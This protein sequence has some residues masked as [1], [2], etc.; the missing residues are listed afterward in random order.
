MKIESKFKFSTYSA[1]VFAFIVLL[2]FSMLI[3]P[4]KYIDN[5]N[6]SNFRAL[7]QASASP[8]PGQLKVLI[9]N[10]IQTLK[11][12]DINGTI[13][14]L[15]AAEQELGAIPKNNENYPSVQVVLTFL[16][17]DVIKSLGNGDN[18]EAPIYLNLAEQ[19]L[20]RI[21]L[22]MSN[23]SIGI[24][25][26]TFLTY[27]NH[28][29]KIRINYQYDWIIDGNSYPTGAGGVVITSFYLPD[30][31]VTGLPFFRIGVDNLTKEF[32]GVPSVSI[33]Q[34]LNRS[35]Q[36]KNSTGFPGF[37]LIKSDTN[38]SIL[39]GNR[40]YTLIWT[41]VHPKYGIRKSIEIA[42]IIGNKG[43]FVD[44]TVADA[45]FNN[46]LPIVEKMINSFGLIKLK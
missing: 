17:T 26:G 38:T 33:D 43:Y 28:R 29:Y 18:N 27:S 25:P 22:Y 20:G 31:N 30:A 37:K 46:Y 9:D 12:G 14:R 34:F 41:Y 3:I 24:P 16:V 13:T 7:A 19:Q 40:A 6:G 35:L 1:L 10:S 15:K 8:S 4:D 5:N 45:K 36:H 32:S 11:S 42:T 21:L 2:I 39:A 23:S 44:Y